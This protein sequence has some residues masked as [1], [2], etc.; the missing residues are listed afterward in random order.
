M[1]VAVGCENARNMITI[2]EIDCPGCKDCIEVFI[3]DGRTTG[4]AA[5]ETCGYMV[6]EN[7]YLEEL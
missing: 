1:S 5:C 6:P 7:I 3:G 2:K 4:D